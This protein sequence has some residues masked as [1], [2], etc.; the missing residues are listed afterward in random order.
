MQIQINGNVEQIIQAG[1]A[2]GQFQSAEDALTV[3][4]QAWVERQTKAAAAELPRLPKKIDIEQLAKEQGVKPFVPGRKHPGVWPEDESVD[5]FI[6]F[7]RELRA[8]K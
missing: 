1:I 3:M 8:G 5:D 2:S 4:S 7:I 6:A